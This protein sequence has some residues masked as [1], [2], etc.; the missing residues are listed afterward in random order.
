[1]LGISSVGDTYL[2]TLLIHGARSMLT[3]TKAPSGWW[4]RLAEL[5]QANV[6]AVAITNKTAL[7]IRTLLAHDRAY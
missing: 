2:S 3:Y 7:T 1:M 4:V 5:Q 6:V